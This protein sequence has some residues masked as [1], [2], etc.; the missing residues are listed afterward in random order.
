MH[1][2][3]TAPPPHVVYETSGPVVTIECRRCVMR[4]ALGQAPSATAKEPRRVLQKPCS[5]PVILDNI[6]VMERTHAVCLGVT[7]PHPFE[8]CGDKGVRA[9]TCRLCGETRADFSHGAQSYPTDR[10]A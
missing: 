3:K 10:A 5:V 7:G 2:P 6:D 4:Q 9:T 1:G 8:P